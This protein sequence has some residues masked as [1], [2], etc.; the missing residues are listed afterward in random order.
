[1]ALRPTSG[2]T[3]DSSPARWAHLTPCSSRQQPV[4]RSHIPSTHTCPFAPAHLFQYK[5]PPHSPQTHPR[6]SRGL[7]SDLG[8]EAKSTDALGKKVPG[9]DSAKSLRWAPADH[10]DGWGRTVGDEVGLASSAT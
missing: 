2:P 5:K 10:Q 4:T 8:E 3:G 9:T 6:W 1:M 7:G